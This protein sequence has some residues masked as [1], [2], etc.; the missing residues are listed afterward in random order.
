MKPRTQ[1]R[2]KPR[3]LSAAVAACAIGLVAQGSLQAALGVIPSTS[4]SALANAIVGPGINIVGTP[5]LVSGVDS[6]GAF[7]GGA[8]AGITIDKGI[9]LTTGSVNN[10][11]GPNNSDSASGAAS[12]IGD[13]NLDALVG[14]P[15]TRDTTY[16]QFDFTTTGGDL[17]F[18]YVFGSEEYNEFTHTQFNDVF[19]FF[20]DGNNI[21][22]IPGTTTPVSIN[23]VNGGNPFGTGA[24]H[25]E[26]FHNND[27]NDGG[28]FFNLQYDGFTDVFTASALGVGAGT[29]TI[30][31]AIS[32]SA[33][34]IYDSGVF[35]QGGS[36]SDTPQPTVPDGGSTLAML[37]LAGAGLLGMARKLKA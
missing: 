16:L 24:D 5:T 27:L 10:A 18:N 25:P 31:L 14:G 37:G 21:A 1:S 9:L 12:G 35:I 11:P 30:K 23:T 8:S 19:G 29:H 3:T 6:A 26:F 22:L 28:P 34:T 4:A 20:L 13:A 2:T 15:V 33:D 17:F 36:F 7:T 32:D